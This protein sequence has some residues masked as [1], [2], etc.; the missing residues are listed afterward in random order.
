MK[1]LTP[2]R[3]A[4]YDR[5]AIETWGI[6]SAVLMENAGRNTYRLMKERYL[7]GKKRIVIVCGR[8]NNGGDGFVVGRYAL[9]DGYMTKVFLLCK[10]DDLRGDAALNMR[11]YESLNGEIVELENE[12]NAV[13]LGVA[14]ADIIVDAIFGTGLSKVVEGKERAVIEEINKSGKPV[15]AIDIP[16]GIDGKTGLAMG[17]AVMATHTFTYAYP[18][19]GHILYPGGYYTGKLTV[20]DIS[21]PDFAEDIIG[22][23]AQLIDGEMIRG[24]IKERLPWT[25]KGSYGHAVV[26]AGSPGKTGA[27]HMASLAALKIG[28]GLVTLIIPSSLNSIMEV[29]LTEVMTYP[30]EDNGTGFFTMSCYKQVKEFVE[31]KDIII[32]G[33]GLS[34]HPETTEFVRQIYMNVAKPFVIDADGINAFIGHVEIFG[35]AG[36][37]AVLTPH[38][39]EFGR[40]VNLSPKL[41]N[42]DRITSGRKF[43][44]DNKV[45]LVLK[46]ARSIFFSSDGDVYINP[47]GNPSLAKGGSGDILTGFIGGLASQ[48]YSLTESSLLGM[49]LHGYLADDWLDTNTDMDLLAGDLIVGAGRVIRALKDGKERVYIEKSL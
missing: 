10:K 46:G 20:V 41:I 14:H 24:F 44:E 3:M 7:Y 17:I 11:L 29:K 23:D 25:H 45:N 43:V 28:A 34:Q 30:V 16:S 19:L 37:N 2:E 9:R 26:I 15:M 40:L 4:K 18:K 21:I 31:D 39:G 38:P 27:A 5:Y 22:I 32:M 48:G 13:K 1:I 8:G 42:Q 36:R 12:L 49:Y 6:P 33:P 47:T 35:K